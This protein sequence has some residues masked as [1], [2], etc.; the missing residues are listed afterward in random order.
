MNPFDEAGN[1]RSATTTD[2]L[3]RIA[4][5]GAGLT[6]LSQG[7]GFIIQMAATVILARLL[8]PEDV[9]LVTMVTTFSLLLVNVGFNGITEAV[10]QRESIDHALVSNLFWINAGVGLALT[11]AFAASGSLLAHFYGDERIGHVAVAMSATILLTSLSVL[12]LAL[13]K[14]AMRFTTLSANDLLA[15]AVSVIA[16]IILGWAAFGYWALVAGAIALPLTTCIGAWT[17][18]RWLPGLP[19]RRQGTREMVWFAAN[20]YG[21]FAANYC[22]RNLDNLLVGWFF[23]PQSL[24]FYKKAYD[25]CVLPIGQLSDPLS[26][27]A[28]P[29]L[30]RLATDPPRQ[31]RF[32]LRALSTLAFAGMGLGGLFVL[33]GRDLIRVL[34]GP[35]WEMSGTI[36][37]F[38]A[39]GI[40]AMLLYVTYSWIHLS[41]GRADRLFRWGLVEF[42]AIGVLFAAG[43]RWGPI[44]LAIAWVASWW[45]LTIPALWYAGR[46]VGLRIGAI[47]AV[48]WRYVIGSTLAVGATMWITPLPAAPIARIV[49]L[50]SAFVAAYGAATIALHGGYAPFSQMAALVRDMLPKN[51]DVRWRR[52][53]GGRRSTAGVTVRGVERQQ[54]GGAVHESAHDI[55]VA[56]LR[57]DLMDASS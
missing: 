29:T 46:P 33:I 56:E 10:V 8:T 11:M 43:F 41:I 47:I 12:H 25:L 19:R 30:S 39:P 17:R 9:G 57:R 55:Q 13:L 14:R 23:G 31:R 3:R 24:G 7:T 50:T 35:Q 53:Q 15:R 18:C 54:S 45:I 51:P 27:V 22:T 38:F 42:T 37:T 44:G 5:R 32:M 26:A 2:T 20:T 40:G 21:H 16:S 1:F 28:V 4:V 36:F 49:A 48:I 52:R 6:A 34:L